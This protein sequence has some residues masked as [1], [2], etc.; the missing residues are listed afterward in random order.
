MVWLNIVLVLKR[1]LHPKHFLIC[2]AVFIIR[3]NVGGTWRVVLKASLKLLFLKPNN[4]VS[5]PESQSAVKI[6]IKIKS[7]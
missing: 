7:R 3:Y 2:C 5:F 6:K 4:N 1:T